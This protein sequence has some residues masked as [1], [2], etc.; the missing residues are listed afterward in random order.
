[1]QKE[2][3]S[4]YKPESWNRLKAK[5]DVGNRSSF[6]SSMKAPAFLFYLDIYWIGWGLT[7]LERTVNFTLYTDLDINLIPK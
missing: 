7:T 4:H 3:K 6:L 1:M 2:P 5:L